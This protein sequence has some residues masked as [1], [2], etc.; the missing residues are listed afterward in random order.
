MAEE[1]AVPHPAQ[2]VEL[3]KLLLRQIELGVLEQVGQGN[4]LS[5]REIR[6]APD[7]TLEIHGRVQHGLV[8]HLQIEQQPGRQRRHGRLLGHGMG[9]IPE[10]RLLTILRV[11]RADL[12]P[13]ALFLQLLDAASDADE[14]IDRL[15]GGIPGRLRSGNLGRRRSRGLGRHRSG[16]LGGLRRGMDVPRGRGGAQDQALRGEQA[17]ECHAA[18][19]HAVERGLPGVAHDR[20]VDGATGERDQQLFQHAKRDRLP[21]RPGRIHS[22]QSTLP[23]PRRAGKRRRRTNKP[24][25]RHQAGGR[26]KKG[27]SRVDAIGRVRY[28]LATLGYC[29]WLLPVVLSGA[30]QARRRRTSFLM[31]QRAREVL[32]L[33]FAPLRTTGDT[34]MRQSC[35]PP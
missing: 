14:I 28:P 22:P 29:L 15:R 24:R 17:E 33:R 20:A 35:S 7:L 19:R 9:K 30:P 26:E 23:T 34:H 18:R 32:R 12:F 16:C 13:D 31:V 21:A 3:P 11:S 27:Q 2:G 5:V 6:P 4:R 1:D 10:Q 25:Q 8:G